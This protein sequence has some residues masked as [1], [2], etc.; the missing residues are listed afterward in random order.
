MLLDFQILKL[1][2]LNLNKDILRTIFGLL[3][4]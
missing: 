1:L 4:I 2:L 3:K